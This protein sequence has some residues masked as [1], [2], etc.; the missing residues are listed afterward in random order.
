MIRNEEGESKLKEAVKRE[1]RECGMVCVHLADT[2]P[3][4]SS[5]LHVR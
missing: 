4:S 2:T 5:P 3:C 1:V